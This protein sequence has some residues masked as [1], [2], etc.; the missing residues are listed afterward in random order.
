MTDIIETVVNRL[1]ITRG[2][3]AEI[4]LGPSPTAINVETADGRTIGIAK[5]FNREDGGWEAVILPGPDENETPLLDGPAGDGTAFDVVEWIER[6]VH[7]PEG[8]RA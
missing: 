1:T 6:L 8:N 7:D 3:N 5:D 4:E 2:I